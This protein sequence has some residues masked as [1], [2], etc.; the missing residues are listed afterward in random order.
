MVCGEWDFQS[1]TYIWLSTR[2]I[3]G[4]RRCQFIQETTFGQKNILSKDILNW[5][6][7]AGQGGWLSFSREL[8]EN[9]GYCSSWYDEH[10]LAI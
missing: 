3:T 9:H 5:G 7:G 6:G 2:N 1:L 10:K 8:C 4:G